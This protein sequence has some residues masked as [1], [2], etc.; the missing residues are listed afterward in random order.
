MG[1]TSHKPTPDLPW[2]Q[3]PEQFSVLLTLGQEGKGLQEK[4]NIFHCL[5]AVGDAWAISLYLR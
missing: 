1:K 5:F 4:K 2:A 3:V